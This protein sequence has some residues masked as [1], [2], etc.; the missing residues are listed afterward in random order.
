MLSCSYL[1]P[2]GWLNVPLP[3]ESYDLDDP[4]V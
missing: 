3:E 4:T 1:L 2:D